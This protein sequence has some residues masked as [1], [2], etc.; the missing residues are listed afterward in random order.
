MMPKGSDHSGKEMH[1][2]GGNRTNKGLEEG[3]YGMCVRNCA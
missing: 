2:K 3:K 1:S